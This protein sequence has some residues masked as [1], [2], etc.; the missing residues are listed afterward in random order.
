MLNCLTSKSAISGAFLSRVKIQ[1]K[2]VLSLAIF[3]KDNPNKF[4]V[5][6]VIRQEI[7]IQGQ[8]L[9]VLKIR[10]IAFMLN[11]QFGVT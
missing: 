6:H 8:L 7:N 4:Y 5:I 3:I 1:T 2:Q 11:L 10:K 9:Y